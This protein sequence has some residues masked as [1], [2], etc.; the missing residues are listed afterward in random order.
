[1][2][3]PN[4]TFARF[5]IGGSNE[6]AASAARRAAE[7]PGSVYN[8]LLIR[9]GAGVG[10]THL[11]HAIANYASALEVDLELRLE[12]VESIAELVTTRI[13]TGDPA[14]LHET[15]ASLGLLLI[16]ELERISGM[17]RTQDELAAVGARMA[18]EGRQ[19]VFASLVAPSELPGLT[20]ELRRLLDRGTVIDIDPPD[21]DLRRALVR[22]V[23]EDVG[24]TLPDDLVRAVA[25][26]DLRDGRVIASTVRRMIALAWAESRS[27]TRDD[28]LRSLPEAAAPTSSG[29]EFGSFLT[30]ISRTLETVVETAPWRRRIGEAILR[31]ESEG[32]RTTRLEQ[33]LEAD[34]PPDVDAFL[35]AFARDAER[36]LEIRAQL[37]RLPAG[38]TLD[39]PA[40][41]AR[42]EE[43]LA[44]ANGAAAATAG[45]SRPRPATPAPEAAHDPWFLNPGK[46][47]LDWT[48]VEARL[49]ESPR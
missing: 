30:D 2:V 44:R 3:D 17:E 40:D 16:D 46:V 12:T 48:E 42:A 14:P 18:D 22:Q 21:P 39:D 8:P 25:E 7:S 36:L 6:L 38:E 5:L 43:L 28:L 37:G 47:I 20:P 15:F 26:Y 32:I 23:A 33:A 34:A 49:A 11:L 29:D 31:W 19:L 24:A 45:R 4:L 27:P 10:K 9:G 41:L 35:D 13:V 1:M